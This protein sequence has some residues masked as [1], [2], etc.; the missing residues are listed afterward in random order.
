MKIKIKSRRVFW[1]LLGVIG[2]LLVI[3]FIWQ[4]AKQPPLEGDWQPALARLSTAEFNGDF[5]TVKNVRNFQYEGSESSPIPAYYDKTYDLNKLTRVWYITDPFKGLSVA[6][7]TFLSFEFS[8]GN[9]LSI[10]IEARKTKGQDYDIFKGILHTYPIMYIAA[11]ERDAIFV[12]A[13]VDKDGL[14]MYPVNADPINVRKLFVAMLNTMND[15]AVHPAWYNTIWANCTST[16]AY[17]INR[18]FPGRLHQWSW[19]LVLSGYADELAL[20]QGLLDTS[21]SLDQARKKFRI[22][23]ISQ[24]MGYGPNY[25]FQLRQALLETN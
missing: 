20:K 13:N 19:P 3:F 1:Y 8:D 22:T 17:Q 7:H 23:E 2:F 4:G 6:A 21:L 24:N 10:T 15:L 25:S 14:Y 16:I 11:D 9:Y 12:R 5:A 18:V